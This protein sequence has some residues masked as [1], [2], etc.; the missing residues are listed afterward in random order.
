[1]TDR[2]MEEFK[3]YCRRIDQMLKEYESMKPKRTADER[4]ILITLVSMFGGSAILAAG[5]IT[6]LYF[7]RA[8]GF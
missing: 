5:M 1:M 7:G 6:A 2:E 3:L 8:C 4:L